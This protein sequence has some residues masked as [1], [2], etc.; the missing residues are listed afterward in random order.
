MTRTV[1]YKPFFIDKINRWLD[2]LPFSYWW[3]S[4]GLLILIG[5]IQ[6]ILAWIKGALPVGSLNLYLGFSGAWLSEALI[7][8][9]YL[10]RGAGWILDE[11]RPM[12]VIDDEQYR[13]KKYEFTRTPRNVGTVLFLIGLVL[14]YF[15]AQSVRE[16]SPAINFT[17]PVIT[18]GL[19]MLTLGFGLVATYQ[20]I[21][22][23][24]QIRAFYQETTD[25]DLFNLTPLYAF[26]KMTAILSIMN[27]AVA[28]LTP[29]ILN[30]Q[31]LQSGFVQFQTYFF[32][33]LSLVIFYF[34][35]AGVN[36]RIIAEKDRMLKRINGQIETMLDRIHRAVEAE[37]YSDARGMRSLLMSLKE[38]KD[39][40]ES[41]PT[42]PWKPATLRGFLS[43]LFLPIAIW[44]I[45]QFLDR[46]I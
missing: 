4:I 19:W 16:L 15:M 9:Y 39:L 33:A 24:R 5:I 21:R 44:L 6:H 31:S 43:A 29:Q 12:L 32:I 36:R 13:L 7:I 41:V 8:I 18:I 3:V 30:P 42:W 25:I 46:I 45:Q 1:P 40:V 35:L 17:N 20:I 27:F 22:Q 26:S 37:D 38:E 34:P 10:E 11:F 2:R 14:A 23:L 28:Y